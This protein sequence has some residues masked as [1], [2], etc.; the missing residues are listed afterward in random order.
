[1]GKCTILAHV[2]NPKGEV[3]ESRLY[4][5]LLHYTSNNR[6]LTKE[7]YAVGTNESFLDK[8]RD[9]AEFDENGEITFKSLQRL[10]NLQVDEDT[11]IQVLNKDLG[12]GEMSYDEAVGKMTSFNR[13][14]SYNDSYM[15][16]IKPS[17]NGKYTL[18]IVKKTRAN[19]VALGEVISKQT[20]QNRIKYFLGKAGVSVEFMEADERIHGRYS[21]E[22][23]TQTANG[24]YQLI[25]IAKGEKV[26][27]ALAEEA[28]HF[29]VAAM[30]KSPLMQRFFN[31]LT[32]DVQKKILGDD[33]DGKYLGDNARREVA[34][35]IVGEAL[36]GN[37]DKRSPWSALMHRIVNNIKKVF[38][39]LKGDEVMKA[40]LE[41][42]EI[43]EYIAEGF[44]SETFE[45][46]VEE[47]LQTRETLYS[48][49]VSFNVRTF[50]DVL[51]RLRLQAA[52]MGGISKDLFAKFDQIAGQVEIGRDVNAPGILGD[53]IALE[54]ITEAISLLSDLMKSEI[55]AL[56]DSVDFS[57]I[58]DF[59]TNMPRNG[60]ALRA[61]RVYVKNVLDIIQIINAATS[62]IPGA[63]TLQ[64]DVHNV[65][66]LDSL[67]NPVSHDL[68][69]IASSLETL[70]K[71]EDGLVNSLLNKE[72]QFF[73][74]FLEQSL[75]SKYISRAARV[76]FKLK[77]GEKLIQFKEAEDIPL[78]DL[79][80]SLDSDLTLFERYIAS[81]SNNSDVIGQIVDKVT[82]HANKLADDITRNDFEEL[83]K[84]RDRFIQLKKRGLISDTREIYEVG[85]DGKL[86]GNIRSAYNVGEWENEFQRF[87]DEVYEDFVKTHDLNGK[88][89][90]E[91]GVMWDSFFKP[92]I[93]GWHLTN[94]K[95][96]ID[97]ITN[98]GRYVPNDSYKD[99]SWYGL[100]D[101]VQKFIEDIVRLKT[102]ID[103][104]LGD[105]HTRSHRAP[106]FKGTFIDKVNNKRLFEGTGKAI[107]HTIRGEIRDTFCESSEDTDYGSGATY[108]SEAEMLFY[109]KL[110]YE[111]EKVNRVPLY[112]INKL[113][114]TSELSTDI[115]HSLLAYS[116]MANQYLAMSQI[117]DTL[118]VGKSVLLERKVEGLKSERERDKTSGA[119]T[120]YTKFLDKQVYGVSVK[121]INI[122]RG[123]LLDKI[124]N[125]FTG[126]ASKIYLGGN[127]AG[128]LV[129]LGTGSIE[130]FKE[131]FAGE[132]F[133]QKD[134]L[135]ANA[136]YLK[137]VTPSMIGNVGKEIKTDKVSLF[138]QY[139]DVL[140]DNKKEWRDWNTRRPWVMNMFGKSLWL[141]YKSGEHYMQSIPYIGLALNTKIYDE[142]GNETTLWD[143][144]QVDKIEDT[145][146]GKRLSL[147]DKKYFKDPNNI[148]QYQMIS[149]I[150]SQIDSLLGASSILG[151]ALHLSVEQQDY[152]RDKGYNIADL[153]GT[154]TQL[155]NDMDSLVWSDSDEA[156]FQA[157][158]REI[159]NRMHGIYNNADKVAAQQTIFFNMLL[160][161]RGYALGMAERR[162]G[163]SKYSVALGGETG[164]SMADF[165]KVLLLPF[166]DASYIPLTMRALLLPFGEGTKQAMLNAGFS[167]HQ[168]RNMRRNF[169]DFSAI[170]ALMLL[171]ALTAPGS[172]NDDDDEEED[173]EANDNTAG[174]IYYFSSRLL[175]EQKAMNTISGAKDES[176]SLLDIEPIGFSIAGDLWDITYGLIGQQFVEP[177]DERLEG[178]EKPDN[179]TDFYYNSRKEGLYDYGDSKAERKIMRMLP[180]YRSVY[181]FQNPYD[182]AA[183]FDYG[184]KVK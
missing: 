136:E 91:I 13:S 117:V 177:S 90:F 16:T 134:W 49:P 79:I 61:V 96:V 28:G 57:N 75:G 173:T 105:V 149:G 129:N 169:G 68:R 19:Q 159:T 122:S 99:S 128:G 64:G 59:Y 14:S 65:Q 114:D 180:Y 27:S 84:L 15:A 121:R 102:N 160:A 95:F 23:A 116:G 118:E 52:E 88:S 103:S 85:H 138:I 156:A 167:M 98:E 107:R 113:G 62:T 81:M 133:T 77:R 147:G 2:R 155:L 39:H 6:Q 42:Q 127:V 151:P 115:F 89:D 17:E 157:K 176:S 33:Y 132:Y 10:A 123:I 37:I 72:S 152:L 179:Y 24:L 87:K 162:F 112:G 86:T 184:K 170:A 38:A 183:A 119:F 161:M 135:K 148:P 8:V 131:A 143:A 153:S 80:R 56:L 34:G 55:P 60:K 108:N 58:S 53:A 66:I 67:G 146:K 54:G 172:S 73:L 100:P 22:N 97:P 69:K 3:V 166:M 106:Q 32:E 181:V 29:A 11:L 71:S 18:S 150:V 126:L 41:A 182:A 163:A 76:V 174:I 48:A 165:A 140:S 137:Y 44:M 74:Q 144:F 101:E 175:R 124:A 83:Q 5:D 164:G 139:F 111:K 78:S 45:G 43:A 130:I 7:Y 20:L 30:G 25:K 145:K 46:S 110:A 31:L 63:Q 158:A 12:A 4:K 50:R 9:D 104:R 120:R 21:T 154:R 125:F 70:M 26:E 168:Y 93:K 82:K 35:T 178:D 1:M 47:A 40:A 94:S 171:K 36:L 142:D 51:G 109:D 92:K 141:P